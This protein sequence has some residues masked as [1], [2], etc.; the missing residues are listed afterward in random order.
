MNFT[1]TDK[2]S[3]MHCG[4]GKLLVCWILTALHQ[5][6]HRLHCL[7]YSVAED[8]VRLFDFEPPP[9]DSLLK[10]LSDLYSSQHT[11]GLLYTNDAMVLIDIV[12]RQLSDLCPGDKVWTGICFLSLTHLC[13]GQVIYLRNISFKHNVLLVVRVL[14][15]YW[16]WNCVEMRSWVS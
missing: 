16:N 7:L 15:Q 3:V 12:L 6:C 1:R 4:T 10:F 8:P 14:L 11:A 5:W 2:L 13:L 9:Q